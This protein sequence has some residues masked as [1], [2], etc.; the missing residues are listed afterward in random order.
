MGEFDR[1]SKSFELVIDT[2]K[3]LI[4]LCTAILG[5]IAGKVLL[6]GND[7]V[8]LITLLK[9]H[10]FLS[11]ATLYLFGSSILF[12]ICVIL[13]LMGLLGDEKGTGIGKVTIYNTFTRCLFTWQLVCFFVGIL[14]MCILVFKSLAL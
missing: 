9:S 6:K 11:K 13:K 8:V 3:L 1:K 5:F 2:V 12:G 7:N 10:L 14:F 4:T